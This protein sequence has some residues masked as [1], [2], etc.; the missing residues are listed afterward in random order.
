MKLSDIGRAIVSVFRRLIPRVEVTSTDVTAALAL[1]IIGIVALLMRF[2]PLWGFET[3]VR[4]FDPW[5]AYWESEYILENGFG[6]WFGWYDTTTWVPFGR[7]IPNSSYP[8]IPFT[9]VI[10]FLAVRSLGIQIDLMTFSVFFPAIMGVF[11]VIATYFLGRELVNSEVGLMAAFFMAILPAYTQR[12]IVGFFDNEAIGIFAII[13]T[14]FFFVRALRKGSVA[15]SI[16]GGISMGYLAASWSVYI[17]LF[18]VFAIFALLMVLLRRYNRRLML[19]YSGTVLGGL[20]I[21]ICVPRVGP[22]FVTSTTGLIPIGVLGLMVLIEFARLVRFSEWRMPRIIDRSATRLR[23]YAPYLFG[24]MCALIVVGLGY[25]FQSGLVINLVTATE[26]DSGFLGG[27]AAKFYTVIDPLIRRS[28]YLLASVGEHLPSPWATFWYNLNFLVLTFPF[29]FYFAFRRESEN[30]LLLIIFALTAIYFTGSMI[31]LALLLAPAAAIMGSYGLIGALRPFRRIYWQRPILTRRRRRITPPT[32]RGVAA[33]TY[34]LLL[35]LL[36]ATTLSAVNATNGMGGP[37][38]VMGWRDPE[39]GD[40][41][42]FRDF[43]ETF[44]WMRTSTAEDAVFASWWDYGYW[45]RVVGNRSTVVDNATKN[46]TQIAWIGR[47][48]MENNPLE[49]AQI[50]KRFGIDYVFVRF[51]GNNP[52]LGG[53]DGKWQWMIRIAGEVFGADQWNESEYWSE[54]ARE[55]YDPFFGC[56]LYN[57]L[58][59]NSSAFSGYNHPEGWPEVDPTQD[60]ARSLFSVFQPAYTSQ[61]QLMKVYEVDYTRLE[62]SFEITGANAYYVNQAPIEEGAGSNVTSIVLQLKNTGLHPIEIDAVE[63]FHPSLGTSSDIV[64]SSWISSTTGNLTLEPETSTVINARSLEDF[65]IGDELEVCVHAAGQIIPLNASV[66]V[67][68]QPRLDYEVSALLEQCYAYTNGTIHVELENTGEGYVEIDRIAQLDTDYPLSL[69]NTS[70][71]GNL[72]FT[73]DQITFEL[74]AFTQHP[75]LEWSDG[76]NITLVFFYMSNVEGGYSGENVT[77]EITVQSPPAVPSIPSSSHSQAKIPIALNGFQREQRLA[78]ELFS[79]SLGEGSW[80]SR[81]FFIA[82]RYF[83]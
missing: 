63:I 37:E 72:L 17:Y 76:D 2:L 67:K 51:G 71:R 5:Y 52:N 70:N 56:V 54:A 46:K 27:L 48:M 64:G 31:R 1:I 83:P 42:Q 34:V 61:N 43:L 6:A 26:G 77:M 13:L 45:T 28:A 15:A 55:W 4:A 36:I 23:P 21:A 57:M 25:L 29:G 19:A 22:D 33:G 66:R 49:A 30:D 81:S 41:G 59:V 44:S 58:Y 53:D 69:T 10:L 75:T 73:N 62:S 20:A 47:L 74:N 79:V 82:R 40:S 14:L 65:P 38:I 80:E 12:T 68:V 50:C 18:Q 60:P 39:T 8:G 78:H 16:L 24:A 35:L 7:N 32:S 11:G 3:L 9:N